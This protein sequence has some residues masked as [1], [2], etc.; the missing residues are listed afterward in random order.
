[1]S[2]YHR[3]IVQ[4][5]SARPAEALP[6]AGGPL[7]FTH[8]EIL[9]RQGDPRVVAALDLASDIQARLSGTRAPIAGLDM[10]RPHIMGIL[11]ATPDSFSDGGQHATVEA[12]RAAARQMVAQG[13]SILDVGGES[14]RPGA[15]FVPVETEIA[16]TAPVISAI[17][18]ESDTLISIDTRKSE[19]AA[20]ALD[21]GAG[22]V[23]DVSGF[24]FDSGLAPLSATRSI[25]VCVMHAQGDPET[26]QDDPHYDDVLLD[27]FDFLNNRI[28]HLEAMGVP[29]G[30]IVA[31]PGIGFGKTL[32]H[33]L[34]LL[35]NIGLFHDLGVPILLGA[36]RKRFIGTIARE[37]RAD[38]RAPGSIAVALAA[39]AQGVQII[40]VHD[41][42]ETAQALRLW[43]AVR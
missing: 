1:M 9:S 32:D 5:G 21:A 33:N 23:N 29:R 24:T 43:S 15:D 26:M 22:M 35:R 10:G 31:D 16:R 2:A 30:Q 14:T 18:A 4:H 40:R 13:V 20:A 19:V 6:V 8:V 11:N 38:A 12:A 17:A 27:V 37:P 7:W 25:P 36:S 39:L 42:G 41:V 34:T 3:P 28:S